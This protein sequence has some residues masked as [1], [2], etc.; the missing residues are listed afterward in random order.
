MNPQNPPPPGWQ[1]PPNP[2]QPY[3][4]Q[5]YAQPPYAQPPVAAGQ[6]LVFPFHKGAKVAL[7][8]VGGLL[9][10]LIVT[11]PMSIWIFVR[12]S[13]GRIEIAGS[14]LIARAL[15]TKRWDLTRIRRLGV[16]SVPIYARGLGGVLARR[17]VGGSHAIHLCTIDDRK[18]K[19]SII[20]SMYERYPDIINQVSMMTRLPVEELKVGAFGPKWPG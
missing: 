10:I 18:K 13:M 6:P 4:P 15:F 14:Q 7:N 20:V 3:P 9:V 12:T 11:I 17:K 5:Q 2:Q 8:I 16:L 1:P 19:S